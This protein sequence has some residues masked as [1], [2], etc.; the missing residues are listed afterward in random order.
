LLLFLSLAGA[1]VF[2][3]SGTGLQAVNLDITTHLG[4]HQTYY[5]DDRLG[6]LLSLEKDA[7]VY[8]FYQDSDNNLLQ[9]LPNAKVEDNF[10]K[11]GL[12]IP[13]PDSQAPFRFK[14][15]APFGPDRI[16]AIALD[17]QAVN[18]PGRELENG[19]ILMSRGIDEIRGDLQSQAQTLFDVSSKQV[20]TRSR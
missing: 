3:D 7:Y 20:V 5:A 17:R 12:F 6:F 10:F 2:A 8:L 9:L 13:V 14:V 19:L 1:Q 16:W 18:L 4:D 15:E 11:A